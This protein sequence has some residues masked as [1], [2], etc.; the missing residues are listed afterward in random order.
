MWGTLQAHRGVKE[1]MDL[2]FQ[3][4]PEVSIILHQHLID[5]AVPRSRFEKL[6]GKFVTLQKAVE[7]IKNKSDKAMSTASA[8]ALAA[9]KK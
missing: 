4:H 7:E 2:K 5:N 6:Q 1:I 8:A 9:K 3:G